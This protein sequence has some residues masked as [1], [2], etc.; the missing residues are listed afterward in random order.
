MRLKSK[1][2]RKGI[3]LDTALSGAAGHFHNNRSRTD[4]P[5]KRHY[6]VRIARERS[7]EDALHEARIMCS[8]PMHVKEN[9]PVEVKRLGVAED[10]VVED[11]SPRLA[12]RVP[13]IQNRAA[14]QA[15]RFQTPL[16]TANSKL[17]KLPTSQAS[18]LP[19]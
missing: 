14:T 8:S 12:P 9:V 3:G 17:P 11:A 18:K 16:P 13:K 4:R 6:A 7:A 1:K 15:R 5:H 19:T 10:Q 2:G